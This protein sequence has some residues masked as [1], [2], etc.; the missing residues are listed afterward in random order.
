MCQDHT[1][2][3]ITLLKPQD[4][5]KAVYVASGKVI[6]RLSS[7]SGCLRLASSG[8]PL[9]DGLV[10]QAPRLSSVSVGRKSLDLAQEGFIEFHSYYLQGREP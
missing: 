8:L 7:G 5:D 1:N 10:I 3:K 2:P 4:T 9:D 6:L